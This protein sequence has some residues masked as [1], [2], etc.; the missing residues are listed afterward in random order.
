MMSLW[1]NHPFIN[2]CRVDISSQVFV[3][4]YYI[5]HSG[6]AC[7]AHGG[8]RYRQLGNA[9]YSLNIGVNV[10]GKSGVRAWDDARINCE[11]FSVGS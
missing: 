1:K 6:A 4:V 3:R 10:K 7:P 5:V 9:I 11:M 2:S 8:I